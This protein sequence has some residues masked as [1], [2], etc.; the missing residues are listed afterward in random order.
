MVKPNGDDGSDISD[1]DFTM[2]SDDSDGSE[3]GGAI[4]ATRS[5][6]AVSPL[7]AR[8]KKPG[9]QS[10]ADV[11]QIVSEISK[12]CKKKDLY[13]PVFLETL[14]RQSH[15]QLQHIRE[16]YRDTFPAGKSG[17]G[18]NFTKHIKAT[19]GTKEPYAKALWYLS[20][21]MWESEANW[22]N[23]FYQDSA[24]K[25]ELVIEAL[26]GRSNYEIR[27]IKDAFLDNKYANSLE[28]CIYAEF[29]STKFKKAVLIILE[30]ERDPEHMEVR[31]SSIRRD[32]E[33]IHKIVTSKDTRNT[34][35]TELYNSIL[36][37]SDKFL[38]ELQRQYQMSYGKRLDEAILAR[39]NNLVGE[40]LAHMLVGVRDATTRDARLLHA[41]LK[42][43]STDLM[44]SRFIRVHWDQEHMEDVKEAYERMYDEQL[45]MA[46]A[47]D[48][49]LQSKV[50]ELGECFC[51]MIKYRK[52]SK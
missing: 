50:P 22:A 30:G 28:N 3:D 37:R 19:F 42:T 23:T 27:Q 9:H 11:R 41:A 34:G 47:K 4:T 8:S 15:E 49:T 17:K 36:K 35:E 12:A 48:K 14:P 46:V 32:V 16:L 10:K 40:L 51:Q 44:I 6:S 24:S 5:R 20:L 43:H 7:A 13:D 52:P 25:N 21:G 45:A 39:S 29:P 38:K 18:I 31:S 33:I 26:A 1:L 2:D